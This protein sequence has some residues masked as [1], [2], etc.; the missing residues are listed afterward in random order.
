MRTFESKESGKFWHIER[1]GKAIVVRQGKIGGKVTTSTTNAKDEKRARQQ[2][3]K[4][5]EAK[6]AR[7]GFVETTADDAPLDPTGQAMQQALIENPDDLAAHM[8][9]ADWLSEQPEPHLQDRAELCRLQLRLEDESLAG[10]ER[11]KLQKRE[12]ELIAL[13]ER[14]LLGWRLVDVLIDGGGGLHD[15][16]NGKP[17][18]GR[19][20]RRGWL[21]EVKVP[22]VNDAIARALNDS[23]QVALLRGLDIEDGDYSEEPLSILA[24]N[25]TLQ[26]LRV[27]HIADV[28]H[29][30]H[31]DTF[32]S[33]LPRL[34]EFRIEALDQNIGNLFGL[35]TLGNLR[36]L[37]VEDAREYDVQ[38]L[39]KNR[40]LTN[41]THL[42]LRP[43]WADSDE[44]P[45]IAAAGFRAIVKSKHLKNLT[46][47]TICR[48]NAGDEGI[49]E[50]VKSGKLSRLVELNLTSGCITNRGA[51]ELAAAEGY[52]HL[53][54]LTLIEN[55]LTNVGI[56][57]LKRKGLTLDTDEQQTPDADGE[58][59][60]GYLYQDIGDYDSDF[61]DSDLDDD[62][63]E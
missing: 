26:N 50:L 47:L 15:Y 21:S 4:K 31:L 57:A 60:D 63:W 13:L 6:R 41:L 36:V 18:E 11:K 32:I 25:N 49:A 45:Y 27:L 5:I 43:G 35:T 53:E 48:T 40:H 54:K 29:S 59:D 20:Y 1:Q 17:G 51:L 37:E 58:Y 52:A 28:A 55:R 34:E 39:A 46:H 56:R 44:G 14:R 24:E 19:T 9:F 10:T 2:Y 3:Q 22:L 33:R 62:D 30:D 23:P 38:K 8:A 12:R 16:A 7:G 42:S 61:F